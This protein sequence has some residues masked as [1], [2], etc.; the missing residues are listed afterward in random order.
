MNLLEYCKNKIE[1]VKTETSQTQTKAQPTNEPSEENKL[2]LSN[3]KKQLE[4]LRSD[5]KFLQ[6][7]FH[8]KSENKDTY[9]FDQRIKDQNLRLKELLKVNERLNKGSP[10]KVI[11]LT[12][13]PNNEVR[14]L[15]RE[16]I[17]LRRSVQTAQET[18]SKT[19]KQI[20]DYDSRIL[21][22]QDKYNKLTQLYGVPE[23]SNNLANKKAYLERKLII[24]KK[25]LHSTTNRM[26]WKIKELENQ[27][28]K[29]QEDKISIQMKIFKK[30]QQQRMINVKTDDYRVQSLTPNRRFS[31]KKFSPD[32]SFLYRPSVK[33]L[34]I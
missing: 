19:Q 17:Q 6:R 7:K 31:R 12:E 26:N 15:E 14:A 28:S 11:S 27:C 4:I 16:L 34:Y 20:E 33:G 30:N 18:S 25:N 10:S 32:I 3:A 21:K 22:L 23:N 2:S 9:V 13:K 1:K 24:L 5:K 8:S 29:L